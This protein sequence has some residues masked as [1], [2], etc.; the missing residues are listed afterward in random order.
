M[1]FHEIAQVFPR[2]PDAELAALAEDIKANGLHHA[3]TTLD[4][5]ILDG[6]NRYAACIMA[7]VEP[8]F[9]EYIGDNPLAFV[10]SENIVRRHLDESQRAMC[11][12]RLANMGEGHPTAQICAVSQPQAAEMLNVGRRSVQS[13][14]TVI[15]NGVPE[16]AQAVDA[17]E[18]AVSR[19]AEIA[20][21]PE[22]VQRETI[23]RPHVANNSGNN[24]WYTPQ[25]YI[26][27]ARDVMGE[28]DLDPASTQLA[29]TVVKARKIYTAEDDGLTNKWRGRVWMNPPYSTELIG[30]FIEKLVEHVTEGSV[31]QA[32]VLVNNATETTWFC[33][34]I[35]HVA[36]AVV[37][38][39]G[40]VKFWKP[41]GIS[42]AP[43][44]GQALVYMGEHPKVFIAKFKHL[45]WGA[46][47]V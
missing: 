13:A 24:E 17:G 16:L 3:I 19:A 38:T 42:G 35:E 14:K 26:D 36:S 4:G 1:E 40:R 46:V 45:G 33:S 30:K 27:A 39:R 44:Q 11:A 6:R 20:R 7:E 9:E 34:L 18:I 23:R 32:V 41:E 12:A 21:E 8:R 29:N 2:L 5:K 43:L 15:A 47:L 31:T 22:E 25:E 37:F 28:I 10:I